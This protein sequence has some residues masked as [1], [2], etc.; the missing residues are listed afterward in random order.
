MFPFT[1]NVVETAPLTLE[2][3]NEPVLGAPFDLTTT[4]IE[5]TAIFHVGIIG[6]TSANVS[7]QF[8]APTADPQCKINASLD[9]VMSPDVVFGGPGTHTWEGIDL[10]GVSLLGF[11]LFFQSATLDLTVLSATTRTSNGIKATT[12]L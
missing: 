11:E 3:V 5:P 6:V 12:G 9:L 8:V 4:N 1:T 2:A 10:T 7:L